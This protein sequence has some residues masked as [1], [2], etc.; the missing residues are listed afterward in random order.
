MDEVYFCMVLH[1][2]EDMRH[3]LFSALAL[4]I[5]LWDR[6]KDRRVWEM[7]FTHLTLF[8][9]CILSIHTRRFNVQFPTGSLTEV[10]KAWETSH[11][12]W[13]CTLWPLHEPH[14]CDVWDTRWV[15]KKRR[16]QENSSIIS[17]QKNASDENWL[18]QLTVCLINVLQF[19][20][21]LLIMAAIAHIG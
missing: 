10:T 3:F 13:P 17:D 20:P 19:H 18:M 6:G 2:D 9:P 12:F 8:H 21:T 1:K 4:Q 15:K 5:P 7:V 11:L 14:L 16:L